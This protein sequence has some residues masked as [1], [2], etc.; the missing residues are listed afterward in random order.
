MIKVIFFDIGRVLLNIYPER[1]LSALRECTGLPKS[2]LEKPLQGD[3]S[4]SYETGKIGDNEFFK[5]YKDALPQPNDL[6][7][8]D[9]FQAWLALLGEPTETMDLARELAKT[10]PVWLASNT[11]PAHIRHGEA[12]GLFDGFAG[13]IYSFEIGI[14]KPS[15]EFFEKALGIAG[16]QAGST[17]FVDDK[18]ENI[19]AA[20]ASGLESIHYLSDRQLSEAIDTLLT[21]S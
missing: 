13:R 7:K 18:P 5:R 8:D 3:I 19:T 15:K 10:Y 21:A 17:L 11:N 2:V 16:A 6:T 12:E 4:D 14:R 1:T 20:E 9:F